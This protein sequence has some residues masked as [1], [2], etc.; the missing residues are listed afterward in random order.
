[1]PLSLIVLSYSRLIFDQSENLQE[2]FVVQILGELEIRVGAPVVVAHIVR[3]FENVDAD[4][5]HRAIRSQAQFCPLNVK[6]KA[7]RSES[8]ESLDRSKDKEEV[9]VEKSANES[10]DLFEDD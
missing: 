6:Y 7:V 4:K 3:S 9:E 8:A 5:Y 2:G 1:M 10:K